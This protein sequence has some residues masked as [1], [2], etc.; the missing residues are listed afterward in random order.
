MITNNHNNAG[1]AVP[2]QGQA[3]VPRRRLHRRPSRE[4]PRNFFSLIYIYIYIC[5]Y[6]Y[7][8][9]SISLSLYIYMYR[10]VHIY[11][12]THVF[13]EFLDGLL[14]KASIVSFHWYMTYIYT[15]MPRVD[16]LVY[17]IHTPRWPRVASYTHRYS[18]FSRVQSGKWAQSLGDSNLQSSFRDETKQWLRD[19]RPLACEYMRTDRS[20]NIGFWV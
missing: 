1:H 11:I 18:Q 9:I 7:I 19:S 5:I 3:H 17:P 10:Y 14:E 8:S 15:C 12:Y 2:E 16:T 13:N 20:L 4:G 6:I